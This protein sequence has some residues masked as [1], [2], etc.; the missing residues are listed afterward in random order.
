MTPEEAFAAIVKSLASCASVGCSGWRGL[1][2]GLESA[3]RDEGEV[4][5]FRHHPAL[6]N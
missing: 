1:I 3:G 4:E 6:P 2:G 5:G